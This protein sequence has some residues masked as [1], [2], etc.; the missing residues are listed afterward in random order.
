MTDI[1]LF[2]INENSTTELEGKWAFLE[3]DLQ[4]LIEKNLEALLGVTL[5]AS[6]YSTGQ[7]HGGRIDTLGIDENGCPVIIEYKRARNENVINQ[8]LFYLDWLMDHCGEFELL[9]LRKVR[10]EVA[11]KIE[12]SSP[13]LIC[14][15][16]D[17]TKYD[18]HAVKQINRNIELVRYRQY[19]KEF[20]LLE[21]VN[22]TTVESAL[23]TTKLN[24]STKTVVE[25]LE[26]SK[27]EL[28][29]LY[30]DLKTFIFSLGDDI[31]VKTLLDYFAFKR[32]R[33]FACVEIHPRSETI[34]LYL[35]ANPV[36]SDLLEEGFSRDVT[37]IG[38][39][40][41]GNLELTLRNSED[42]EKAKPLLMVSYE[43]S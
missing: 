13:R 35:K 9:V 36:S 10:A 42:L 32:M 40:G 6:E 43:I 11:E 38:H 7:R 25:Y 31:Q 26:Q 1:K 19:E 3:R 20:L 14:I 23:P 34:L 24:K 29:K 41:T 15:A 33:N 30:E 2:R 21:L 5:L 12:W 37:N 8:G 18:E 27:P 4:S 28:K 16:G 22:A 17:Y 39:F